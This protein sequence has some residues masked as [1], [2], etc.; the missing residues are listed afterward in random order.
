LAILAF[1]VPLFRLAVKSGKANYEASKEAAKHTLFA[2]SDELN[3]RYH[4]KYPAAYRINFRVQ[5]N[6]FIK[7]KSASLITVLIS[8]LIAGVLIRRICPNV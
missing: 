4:E 5:R 8:V 1:S 6:R 2:Y 7:M 3:R